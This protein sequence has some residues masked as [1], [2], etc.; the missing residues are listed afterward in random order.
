MHDYYPECPVCKGNPLPLVD[1][2]WM[3][4]SVLG[5]EE[6]PVKSELGKKHNI[7]MWRCTE[8]GHVYN[9]GYDD[10]FSQVNT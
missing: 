8:C 4:L 3:P 2:G 6:D 7:N 1:L 5:L 10:T 9:E